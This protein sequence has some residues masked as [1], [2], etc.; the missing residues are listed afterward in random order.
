MKLWEVAKGIEEG[1]YKYGDRFEVF[2][3]DGEFYY[4]QVGSH[5]CLWWL[6]DEEELQMVFIASYNQDFW[7][8]MSKDE[9]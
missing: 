4:A 6:K 1:V 2:Y 5:G 7:R 8:L 9:I 3:P